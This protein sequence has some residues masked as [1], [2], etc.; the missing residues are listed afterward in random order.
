MNASSHQY[1]EN[2]D[3]DYDAL[4]V[5]G[6]VV[7]GIVPGQSPRV[8]R[9]AAKFAQLLGVPLVGAYVDTTRFVTF[10]EPGGTVHSAA[11][12]LSIQARE[13]DHDNVVAET[14]AALSDTGMTCVVR[15][16]VGDPAFAIRDL[17]DEVHASLI[18]VGTRKPGLGES[19]REFITGSVAARLAHRQK[20]N[21]LVVPQGE[22]IDD[23]DADFG[24]TD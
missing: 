9:E 16:L 19:L 21:I 2:A 24:I 20:R 3:V 22:V 7:V 15:D 13:A 8:V 17:A 12:D 5:N 11:L 14:A 18:V 10:E 1:H 23:D 6:A 4:A